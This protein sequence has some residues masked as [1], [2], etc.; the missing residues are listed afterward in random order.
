MTL[1]W[2]LRHPK[3]SVVQQKVG[4][5]WTI[6]FRGFPWQYVNQTWASLADKTVG[7]KWGWNIF[8][9]K[10]LGRFGGGWAFQFGVTINKSLTDIVFDLG[11]G[12]VRIT[13]KSK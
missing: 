5:M 7:E 13:R 12:S 6:K 1:D 3:R 10:G 2:V 8:S 11:I 9:V 4:R